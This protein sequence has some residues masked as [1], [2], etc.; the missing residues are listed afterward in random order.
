AG[1]GAR[2]MEKYEL[3]HTYAPGKVTSDSAAE[4]FILTYRKSRTFWSHVS[5]LFPPSFWTCS[6]LTR[7]RDL[8]TL[9]SEPIPEFGDSHERQARGDASAGGWPQAARLVRRAY[10]RAGAAAPRR[11]GD[12]RPEPAV[13]AP[14]CR[15]AIRHPSDRLSHRKRGRIDGRRLCP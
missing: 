9:R 12:V 5:S 14:P 11:G 2:A 1:A 6:C 15:A 7:E 4:T 13:G 8:S 10:L 3:G